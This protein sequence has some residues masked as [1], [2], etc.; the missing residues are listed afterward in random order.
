[1]GARYK[2]KRRVKNKVLLYFFPRFAPDF[3]AGGVKNKV[4][5]AKKKCNFFLLL[6]KISEVSP[7]YFFLRKKSR[8]DEES[9]RGILL[10]SKKKDSPPR[11]YFFFTLYLPMLRLRRTTN[12]KIKLSCGDSNT[13]CKYQKFMI[14]PLIDRI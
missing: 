4:L 12:I 5:E 10:R 2:I 14:Y 9:L 7:S 1:M 8:R 11:L 3:F 6:E 13:D